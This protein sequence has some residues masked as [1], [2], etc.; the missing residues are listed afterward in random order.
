MMTQLLLSKGNVP[1]FFSLNVKLK[2][3]YASLL[4]MVVVLLMSLLQ[5]GKCIIFVYVEASE[6]VLFAVDESNWYFKNY[7]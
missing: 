5:I 6:A 2:T 1:V 3:R 4:L 7:S